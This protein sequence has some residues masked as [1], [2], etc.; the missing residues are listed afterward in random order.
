[1]ESEKTEN[2]SEL[3]TKAKATFVKNKAS[4]PLE[5]LVTGIISN[6]L[7]QETDEQGPMHTLKEISEGNLAKGYLCFQFVQLTSE[8][9][10]RVRE[11]LKDVIVLEVDWV[12]W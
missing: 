11:Q 5:K 10:E 3:L 8:Q 2:E 12:E 7:K 4:V 9:Y 1:M 6:Y